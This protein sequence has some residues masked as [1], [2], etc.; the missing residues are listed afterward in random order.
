MTLR[1]DQAA[2]IASS[3]TESSVISLSDG[4]VPAGV[5]TPDTMTGTTLTFEA[6]RF[7]GSYVTIEDG[8]GNDYTVIISG[9]EFI[10]LEPKYFWGVSAFKIVSGSTEAAARTLYISSRPLS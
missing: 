5:W 2:T 3:G 1:R 10:P 7:D 8:A 9:G 6:L 4:Y